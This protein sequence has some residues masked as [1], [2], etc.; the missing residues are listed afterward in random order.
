MIFV[1]L[2]IAVL[3]FGGYYIVNRSVE[4]HQHWQHTFDGLSFSAE[5]FYQAVQA[6]ITKREIPD[7]RFSRV[8]YSQKGLFSDKR[9]YLHIEKGEFIYDVCAAPYGTGFFVSMW[10]AQRPSVTKKLGRKVKALEAIVDSQSYYTIDTN[11]MIH[12]A[13][14]SGFHE[15]IEEM[16]VSKGVRQ[17]S[18]AE[19]K[20]F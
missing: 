15:A 17:L 9:E 4:N 10:F 12:G 7:I 18:N 8:N 16:T 2:L 13:I 3:L 5:E 1:I 14:Q 20:F 6:A 11:A 19:L